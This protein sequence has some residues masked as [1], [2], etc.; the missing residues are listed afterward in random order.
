VTGYGPLEAEIR[1]RAAGHPELS[2]LGHRDDM[3]DLVGA[4]DLICLTSDFE[5]V[6]YALLEAMA[7]ARPVV[8]MRAGALADVIVDGETGRLVGA[9][10]VGAL[11]DALVELAGDPAEATRLGAA[12][13]EVQRARYDANVMCDAYVRLFEALT[14]ASTAARAGAATATE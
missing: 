1:A 9:G 6:P 2:I 4:S 8:A 13:R 11:T 7:L 5:A 12:G 3:A 14:R 10:D